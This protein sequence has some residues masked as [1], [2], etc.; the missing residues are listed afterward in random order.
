ML[1][2]IEKLEYVIN[3]VL[4][5]MLTLVVVLATIDLGWIIVKDIL[6][7]PVMLLEV[8]ELLELFGAFLLVLIGVEL[9]HT[10][11]AYMTEKVVHVEIILAVGIIAIARKAITLEPNEMDGLR[12][13]GTAAIILALTLGYYF[14]KLGAHKRTDS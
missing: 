4:L 11:K 10:V 9:L 14:V 13:L 3:S 7:P 2:T 6:T 5:A 12:L 1:K 8:D